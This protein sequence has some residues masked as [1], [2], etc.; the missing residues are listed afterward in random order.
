MLGKQ[1]DRFCPNQRAL[2]MGTASARYNY[3]G[4]ECNGSDH[5]GFERDQLDC[6]KL[7]RERQPL[8]CQVV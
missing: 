1:R 3:R 5:Q 6:C 7:A 8:A 2:E 4:W